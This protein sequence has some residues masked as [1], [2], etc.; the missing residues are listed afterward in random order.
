MY[1]IN[2]KFLRQTKLNLHRFFKETHILF[3]C[4]HIYDKN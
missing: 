3:L 2:N 4:I 1:E